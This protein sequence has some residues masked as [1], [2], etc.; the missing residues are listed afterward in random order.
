MTSRGASETIAERMPDEVRAL[1][2][3][4]FD[5]LGRAAAG[6]ASVQR[7]MAERTFGLIG[8]I[9]GVTHQVY[10]AVS[11]GVE[12]GL[13][14]GARLVGRGAEGA[15]GRLP[16]T[17]DGR[18]LSTTAPGGALLGAI[19]GLIGDVLEQDESDLQEPMCVRVR[20]RAVAAE[21]DALAEAFPAAT[22]RLVVF[23]HGL[24]GT[25]LT[26]RLGA[27]A[28]GETYGSRLTRD[29]GATP[30]YVRYNTGRHVSENGRS[31]AE[32]LADLVEAWPVE[33]EQIALVGHSMGGLVC[34][35]AC[36]RASLDD[37]AWT[38]RVRHVISLGTPHMGA[39]LEQGAHYLSHQLYRLPETRAFGSFLRRR[40]AGIRDLRQ[41]SL[42][43]EDWCSLDPDSLE[44]VAVSEVPLL[45]GA[46]HCFVAATV[47]AD[48]SHP[49]SRLVGDWLVLSPSASGRGGARRIPFEVENGMHVGGASHMALLNHP[50]VYE[51]LRDWLDR[52]P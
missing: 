47:T 24:M 45:P 46:T 27:G 30:I 39:P 10:G 20:G 12:T 32:L 26:W 42:V 21:P 28:S 13:R 15:L 34:R 11:E 33:V 23:V 29:I 31:L 5:E 14:G 3:L 2:R 17:A 18:P 19:N 9:A 4:T 41:G 52:A 37:A 22:P 35:S 44:A 16:A 50:W 43:D 7:A 1:S 40:S 51:R 49:I 6:I 36:H 25:E 48:E 8:P 38:G